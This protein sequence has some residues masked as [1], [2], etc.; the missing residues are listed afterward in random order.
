MSFNRVDGNPAKVD[1]TMDYEPTGSV[2]KAAGM[3]GTANR[4]IK[5]DLHRLKDFI[6]RSGEEQSG[7]RG[8]I[9]PT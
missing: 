9:N 4:R 8:R 5:G 6:E 1:P 7:W 3:T 2:E